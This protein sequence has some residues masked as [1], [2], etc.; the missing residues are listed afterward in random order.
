MNRSLLVFAWVALAC[1]ASATLE[2]RYNFGSQDYGF[3]VTGTSTDG[4][5]IQVEN[6][7]LSGTNV[8]IGLTIGSGWA[9]VG[10]PGEENVTDAVLSDIEIFLLGGQSADF[11]PEGGNGAGATTVCAKS[12]RLATTHF[13]SGSPIDVRVKCKFTFTVYGQQ[14]PTVKNVDAYIRFIAYNQVERI[15]T[16]LNNSGGTDPPTNYYKVVADGVMGQTTLLPNHDQNP[17]S[18]SATQGIGK[19]A[20]LAMMK[21]GTVFVSA[22]HGNT[23]SVYDSYAYGSSPDSDHAIFAINYSNI[24]DTTTVH[25]QVL[26]KK[27]DVNPQPFGPNNETPGFNL[28]VFYT[29]EALGASTIATGFD[30]SGYDRAVIGFSLPIINFVWDVENQ[31]LVI[32][33]TLDKHASEVFAGLSQGVSIGEAVSNAED[34]WLAVKYDPSGQRVD[35]L[36]MTIQ[37]DELTRMKYV[38]FYDWEIAYALQNDINMNVNVIDLSIFPL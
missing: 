10:D 36:P 7:K 11:T 16:T 20:L 21:P 9:P 23:T 31:E 29:C 12:F 27:F 32:D 37:G 15:S 38:Y 28:V 25:G 35:T 30:V 34:K 3:F 14:E 17:A 8:T 24:S 6:Q 5:P 33:N 13:E 19:T 2:R 26:L 22:A 1:S 4:T 18:I